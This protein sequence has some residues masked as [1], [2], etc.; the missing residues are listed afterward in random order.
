MLPTLPGES[1]ELFGRKGWSAG[2]IVGKRHPVSGL[3]LQTVREL[4]RLSCLDGGD[5]QEFSL[6]GLNLFDQ[7]L[8]PR[9]HQEGGSERIDPPKMSV[10]G[11]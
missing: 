4:I 1:H 7:D 10:E 2:E 5:P 9:I 8:L 11:F 6:I 3:F